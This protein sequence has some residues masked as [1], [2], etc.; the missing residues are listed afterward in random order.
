M[1]YYRRYMGAYQ[2]RTTRLSMRDHG[3]YSLMLDFYYAEEQPLPLEHEDIYD[4]CKARTP[5]DRKSVEKV[6]R[7]HFDRRGDGY[8]NERADEEIAAAQQARKNGQGGGRPPKTG[9]VT[10]KQTEKV[11][12]LETRSETK[13]ITGSE[14]GKVTEKGG[15]SVHPSTFNHSAFQPFS[16]PTVQPSTDTTAANRK[17]NPPPNRAAAIAVLIRNLEKARGKATKITSINPLVQGWADRG[18]TDEQITQAY[19][20]AVA[21]RQRDQDEGPVNAKFLDSILATLLNPPAG[22]T[23]VNGHGKPWFL[24]TWTAIVAKGAEKGLKE[25]DFDTPPAFRAAVLKAHGVTPDDVRKAEADWRDA[26]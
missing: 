19:E 2:K 9:V 16:L 4:I 3:A 25:A 14:T 24:D 5:D 8:H 26:A 10:G 15:G 11:T 21:A 22:T 12:D 23:R 18:V 6:L 13:P 7:L 20:L 17:Q 1:I